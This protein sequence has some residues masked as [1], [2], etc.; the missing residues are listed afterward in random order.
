L[1]SFASTLIAL[2]PGEA[3][4]GCATIEVAAHDVVDEATP[5]ILRLFEP[6]FPQRLDLLV[7]RLE[8]LIQ[9]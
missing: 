8:K 7:V 6:L 9:G 5:E 4:F 1:S 2:E 3:C